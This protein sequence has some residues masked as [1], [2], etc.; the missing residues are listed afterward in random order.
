MWGA[1]AAAAG[2]S[3]GASGAS[4]GASATSATS[5]DVV[6][7]LLSPLCL[8]K[9]RHNEP[10]KPSSL[11]LG[12]LSRR[13]QLAD[14][15]IKNGKKVAGNQTKHIKYVALN[16]NY[17]NTSIPGYP[18]AHRGRMTTGGAGGRI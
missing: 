4:P 3:A 13:Y 18:V 11:C 15:P 16:N 10:L 1:S 6:W 17:I 8:Q 9:K 12:W 14:F 5:P 7:M 2:A